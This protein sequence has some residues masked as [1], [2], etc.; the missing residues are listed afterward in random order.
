M[1]AGLYLRVKTRIQSLGWNWSKKGSTNLL[2]AETARPWSGLAEWLRIAHSLLDEKDVKLTR[3][4][5]QSSPVR[6]I[7]QRL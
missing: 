2:E 4:A 7:E 1:S 5:D 3:N 6:A